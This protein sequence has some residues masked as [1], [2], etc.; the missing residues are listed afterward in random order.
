MWLQFFLYR[1]VNLKCYLKMIE[2]QNLEILKIAV[3]L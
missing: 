3:F 1:R 2:V